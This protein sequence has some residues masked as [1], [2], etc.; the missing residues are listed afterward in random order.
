MAA[1]GLIVKVQGNN[2]IPAGIGENP[3][4]TSKYSGWQYIRSQASIG[5]EGKLTI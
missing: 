2:T 1:A 4:A 5:M 3:L